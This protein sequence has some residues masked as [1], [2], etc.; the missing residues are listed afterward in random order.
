MASEVDQVEDLADPY[1]GII[2]NS[3]DSLSNNKEIGTGCQP[4]GVEP[5]GF[6]YNGSAIPS[7]TTENMGFQLLDDF[8]QENIMGFQLH[9]ASNKVITKENLYHSAGNTLNF[10]EFQMHGT[11][12]KAVS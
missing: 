5:K 1:Q 9:V 4:L 8:L 11:T 6:P 10:E 2:D 12:I 7:S 3:F